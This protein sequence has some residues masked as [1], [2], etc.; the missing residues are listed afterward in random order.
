MKNISFE[1]FEFYLNEDTAS[2]DEVEKNFQ[3]AHRII[4][5]KFAKILF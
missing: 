4:D 3:A 5:K 2:F 1:N